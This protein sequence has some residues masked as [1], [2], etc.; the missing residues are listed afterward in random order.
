MYQRRDL[1]PAIRPVRNGVQS[2]INFKLNS[3]KMNRNY[4]KQLGLPPK[5][6]VLNYE[7]PVDFEMTM[8]S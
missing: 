5:P 1:S 3:V 6:F 2:D 4:Q 7:E 8:N